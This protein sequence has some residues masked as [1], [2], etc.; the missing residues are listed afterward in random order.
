MRHS[1]A[2]AG[3]SPRPGPDGPPAIAPA[4]LAVSL[5]LLLWMGCSVTDSDKRVSPL[6]SP[7][8]DYVLRVEKRPVRGRATETTWQPEILD[9]D[10]KRLLLDSTG[11]RG[12]DEIYWAWDEDDRAW[13]YSSRRREVDVIERQA[14][15]GG[16][17][18]RRVWLGSHPCAGSG[19][20][21]PP[22]SIY[23]DE[24][25]ERIAPKGR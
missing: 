11:F 23:P 25:R 17:F 20:P 16:A 24:V 5:L 21:C 7:S 8:G 12:D 4:W 22:L 13:F 18:W 19:E 14:S 6:A 3:S 10:G 1:P 9:A 2:N 15:T